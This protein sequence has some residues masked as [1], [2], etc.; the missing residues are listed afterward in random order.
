M[1]RRRCD[2]GSVTAEFAAALPA[3]VLVLGLVGAVSVAGRAQVACQ[4]AAFAAAR[5]VARGEPEA[6]AEDIVSRAVPQ[7]Q[8]RV[9]AADGQLVTVTVGWAIS[10]TPSGAGPLH[11]SCSASAVREI[12]VG[13]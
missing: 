11:L 10:G 1:P 2:G 12:G 7:A 3:V 8:V 4:G 13:G 6:V 9:G 5:V